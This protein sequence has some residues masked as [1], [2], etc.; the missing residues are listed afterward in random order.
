M[1]KVGVTDL[2]Q[3]LP[4]YLAQVRKGEPIQ[5]TQH[6]KVVARLVPERDTAQEARQQLAAWRKTARIGDVLSPIEE[7]WSSEHGRV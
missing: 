5:I 4:G 6:G 3:H 2:R 1:R 7:P